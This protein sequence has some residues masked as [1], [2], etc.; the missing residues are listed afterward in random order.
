MGKITA[1]GRD[2]HKK[3]LFYFCCGDIPL[4]MS[5]SPRG[6]A[7]PS[8][9]FYLCCGIFPWWFLCLLKVLGDFAKN[10]FGRKLPAVV[11]T[12]FTNACAYH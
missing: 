8:G 4:K 6:C 12:N 10:W 2:L 3:E 11:V 7:N 9:D 5:K 1:G